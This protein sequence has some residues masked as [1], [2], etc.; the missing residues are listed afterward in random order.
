MDRG[1]TEGVEPVWPP[2][3]RR[4]DRCRLIDRT[5]EVA[6]RACCCRRSDRRL[7]PVWPL[8]DRRLDRRN[9]VNINRR[10]LKVDDDFIDSLCVY[11]VHQQHS[12]QKFRLNSNSNSKLNSIALKSDT[13]KSHAPPLFIHEVGS[14]KLR[15]KLILRVLKHLRK[16]SSTRKKLYITNRTK[17]GLLPNSTP[18]PIRTQYLHRMPYEISINHVHQL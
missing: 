7:P 5:V 18:H 14:L 3:E 6:C 10:T 15:T 8:V 2:N 1:L 9:P 16:P 11:K 4:S 12:L 17:F 13:E